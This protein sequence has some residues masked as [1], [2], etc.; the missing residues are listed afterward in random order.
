MF[1][2]KEKQAQR[3]VAAGRSRHKSQVEFSTRGRIFTHDAQ[4]GFF[5]ILI[6]FVEKKYTK[7]IYHLSW[8]YQ[9]PPLPCFIGPLK[10][11]KKF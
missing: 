6:V 1:D 11:N 8:L 3:R 7:L 4:N 10:I 9:Y 5:V 2:L